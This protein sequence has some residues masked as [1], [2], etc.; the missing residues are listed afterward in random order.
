MQAT[1]TTDSSTTTTTTLPLL[2]QHLADLRRSGLTDETIRE[3]QIHSI[4]SAVEA[5]RIL[6]W[7]YPASK[8]VPAMAIPFFRIDGSRNGFARLRPDISQPD[9]NK[10]GKVRKYEQP[11]GVSPH[12]YFP[13]AAIDAINT[14]GRLIAVTEGEKKALAVT[15][16]GYPCIG[17]TGV[18]AWQKPFP[19][20]ERK[21]KNPEDKQAEL[22]DDLAQIDW[23][24][25]P[26]LIIFDTDSFRNANNNLALARFALVISGR[27]ADPCIIDLP[28]GPADSNGIPG[29]MGV[30]DFIVE[31]GEEAFREVIDSRLD[32][33]RRP[34]ELQEYRDELKQ[35][36][37]DSI[38]VAGIWFCRGP[39]GS[40]KTTSGI[41]AAQKA[42][43]SLTIVP[44]HKNCDEIEEEY[45]SRGLI[46]RKYPKL[47][48]D[49][50]KNFA[51]AEKAIRAGL[52]ASS[53]VCLHDCYFRLQCDYHAEMKE[54]DEAA[55]RISTHARARLSFA[56]IAKGRAYISIDEDPA[57]ILRPILDIHGG[58]GKVE[59]VAHQAAWDARKKE[60]GD[61]D[62]YFSKME[63]DARRLGEQLV[64]CERAVKLDLPASLNAIPNADAKLWRAMSDLKVYPS[65]DVV[66]VVKALVNGDLESISIRVDQV[67]APTA[68]GGGGPTKEGTTKKEPPKKTVKT[69]SAVWRPPLPAGATIW[70]SDATSTKADI[71]ALVGRPVVDATPRGRLRKRHAVLQIAH[72]I[73]KST[74]TNKAVGYLRAL[75]TAPRIRKYHR[76]GVICDRVHVPAIKGTAQKKGVENLEPELRERIA[77][78][79]YYRSG[80]SRGSNDWI[81]D[82]DLLVV[83]G[84]PRVPPEV[85]KARLLQLGHTKAAERDGKWVGKD[86]WSAITPTGRRRIIRTMGYRDWDWHQAAHAIVNAELQQAIGRARII[87]EDGIPVIVISC[88]R[89]GIPVAD[90]FLEPM[91]NSEFF[92]LQAIEE[93]SALFST[94]EANGTVS[95]NRYIVENSADSQVGTKQ[96]AEKISLEERQTR[97]IL[98]RLA[99]RGLIE[100]IGQ[101]GGWRLTQP[102]PTPSDSAGGGGGRPGTGAG[103]E[104]E[105][106]NREND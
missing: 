4:L 20:A 105:A 66:R 5:K 88:E 83:L 34:R 62:V 32:D 2:P 47:C 82:C 80:K 39:V 92:A 45:C 104:S 53:A 51:V 86:Y 1:S 61:A 52:S 31:Y 46:A 27:D 13:P 7:K 8:I 69:L 58:F 77:K 95:Y 28:V 85:V 40:G 33:S 21:K 65:G 64:S 15:Q 87:C 76:I 94:G 43:T 23:T 25:R 56:S 49:T 6:N 14:P 59:E 36:R 16:A 101:R 55:H 3:S 67:F 54:A 75:M 29:K 73:K 74:S 57:S 89:L 103:G 19:E 50:C 38:G 17:L 68:Q 70:I 37:L 79:E 12:A 78:V 81:R 106:P 18:S 41:A 84:T 9:K 35:S 72:D 63:A 10:P 26:T 11:C 44:T 99:D 71:E 96:V 100:R 30:D 97:K 91:G 42:Q 90:F 60:D 98:L 102:A 22:I 48:K 93:L 24:G